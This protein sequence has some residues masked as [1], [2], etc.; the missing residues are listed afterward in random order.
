MTKAAGIMF[1]TLD[2]KVLFL[3]RTGAAPDFPGC[4]DFPGGGSMDGEMPL[5]T[6]EREA[7]EEIGFLPAGKRTLHVRQKLCTAPRPAAPEPAA[8]PLVPVPE[9]AAVMAADDQAGVVDFT[10]FSQIVSKEFV[11]QLDDEHDGWC[12]APQSAPPEPL[13]PGCKVA[14]D[15]MRM[16]ELDVAKCIRD[17]ILVSPQRFEN[18]WLFAVRITG[19]GTAYRNRLDEYAYR[20]PEYYLTPQFLE[21]CSGLPVI[22]LHP[23]KVVLNSK[24]FDDRV[25]GSI[26][27]PYLKGDEVW[28]IARIY[29]R[30]A[31][32]LMENEEL[33]TS[34]TVVW[35]AGSNNKLETEDG[36][37]LLI[38]GDPH[39]I[40]HVAICEQGVWDKGGD[41]SGVDAGIREDTAMDK[42]TD[43]SKS[44]ST[45]AADSADKSKDGIDRVLESLGTLHSR[46]DSLEKRMDADDEK[47]KE[48][49][50]EDKRKDETAEEKEEDKKA[51]A[52]RDDR[53]RDDRGRDDKARDDKSRDDKARKDEDE[54]DK[55]KDKEKAGD[56]SRDDKARKDE[57]DEKEREE[58]ERMAAD[59]RKDTKRDDKARDDRS[60]DDKMRDDR[61]RDDAAIPELR[62][63]LDALDKRLPVMLSDDDFR[64]L[65]DIQSRADQ[66]LV[67]FGKSAPRALHGESPID[68][69]VRLLNM[70]K[71]HSPTFKGVS[72]EKVAAADSTAL[73]PIED[74]IM[75]DAQRVGTSPTTVPE[76]EL[77]CISRRMPSGHMMNE[78]V[79]QPRSW[80]NQ[81]AGATQRTVTRFNQNDAR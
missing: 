51:D 42:A 21:R 13:H 15:R 38:E 19:T 48:D 2:G 36:S 12:W 39:L 49:K 1:T 33:S 73:A 66:V 17:G 67:L 43:S 18:M 20:P 78:Y 70:L 47:E 65:T 50:R 52:K 40:D 4:W 44:Q 57:E 22:W 29:N 41:P 59:K 68:Y 76:G 25:I 55:E 35:R 34:P 69:R 62:S 26:M 77:R 9:G 71:E 37:K 74:T 58:A 10:T 56:K 8:A 45:A 54:D 46:M 60:R 64:Q 80:M 72:L 23:K 31:A 6:A 61:S 32:A 16:N 63:R 27:L 11:P 28:G 30:D 24:E 81:F 5:E 3:R 53:S 75:A 7:S 14:L 79:G